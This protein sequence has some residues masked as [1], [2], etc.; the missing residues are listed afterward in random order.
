MDVSI[1]VHEQLYS[2]S[3]LAT[4]QK[5]AETS[6]FAALPLRLDRHRVPVR[7][8]RRIKAA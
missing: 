3:E 2:T 7:R 4:Q 1:G 8:Q 5:T 6:K